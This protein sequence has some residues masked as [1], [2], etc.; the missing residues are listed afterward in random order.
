MPETQLA[1]EGLAFERDDRPLFQNLDLNLT[2]GQLLQI[3]GANGCGKTTLL[4]LLCG[5]LTPSAGTIR[6]RGSDIRDDVASFHAELAY[7]GHIPAVKEELSPFENVAFA[8]ALA[9]PRVGVT[10]VAAL[11]RVR[12]PARC[13]EMPCRQLSAGQRR[14]VALARLLATEA[15]LWILDEPFTALD[16]AGRELVEQLL[17]EHAANGGIAILTTHHPMA[18]SAGEVRHLQ[19]GAAA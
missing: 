18:I 10:P 5:L 3:E 15:P 13:L 16:P 1:T 9:T 12:L 6:W 7:V 14:R 8:Q 17:A 4:K 19:L 11:A 2:A